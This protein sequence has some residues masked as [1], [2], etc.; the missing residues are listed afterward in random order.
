MQVQ[1]CQIKQLV[2]D[3]LAVHVA[4]KSL[5]VCYLEKPAFC[6]LLEFSFFHKHFVVV[7]FS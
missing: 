5:Q 4:K 7:A 1:A 3:L 2:A 6:C